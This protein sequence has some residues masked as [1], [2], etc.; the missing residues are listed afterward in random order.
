MNLATLFTALLQSLGVDQCLFPRAMVSG[1]RSP[2]PRAKSVSSF[3]CR[4]EKL[5]NVKRC[6]PNAGDNITLKEKIDSQ[7]HVNKLSLQ[8]PSRKRTYAQGDVKRRVPPDLRISRVLL[9]P[10]V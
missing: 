2:G 7:V 4:R 10:A 6:P 1:A 5:L 9:V 3:L 8:A